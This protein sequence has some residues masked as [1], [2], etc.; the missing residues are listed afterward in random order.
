M[1]TKTSTT[2][3][4]IDNILTR[5][6]TDAALDPFALSAVYANA[7]ARATVK[8]AASADSSDYYTRWSGV[9]GDLGW[10]IVATSNADLSLSARSAHPSLADLLAAAD[11]TAA[12][13]LPAVAQRAGEA[14]DG[15]DFWWGWVTDTPGQL[16][17]AFATVDDAGGPSF[18]VSVFTVPTAGL[19]HPPVR[20]LGRPKPV[21]TSTWAALSTPLYKPPGAVGL[22]HYKATLDAATFAAGEAQVRAALAGK[23]AKHCR[24]VA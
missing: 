7:A 1:Q 24:A 4:A 2:I 11:P 16:S 20:I 6:G 18:A 5:A 22:R 3:L 10:Q 19:L 12:A 8:A 14:S 13:V 9:L 23:F 17:L 21:D 15:L